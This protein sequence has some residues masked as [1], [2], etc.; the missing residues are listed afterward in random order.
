MDTIDDKETATQDLL[1]AGPFGK[2]VGNSIYLNKARQVNANI[3]WLKS[4]GEDAN[5]EKL[6][7]Q[8][9]MYIT[10]RD[11]KGDINGGNIGIEDI[12]LISGR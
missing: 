11:V 8:L 7:E 6:E 5:A 3:A 4:I 9:K 1:T 12:E 2:F 10:E